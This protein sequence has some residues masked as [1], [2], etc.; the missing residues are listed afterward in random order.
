[1]SDPI[2]YLTIAFDAMRRK[3]YSPRNL[4][5]GTWRFMTNEQLDRRIEDEIGELEEALATGNSE[6]ILNE[7]VDILA[8]AAMR[9]DPERRDG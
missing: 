9:A 1:M 3:A 8:F 5:K 4:A 6:L 7:A 2:N